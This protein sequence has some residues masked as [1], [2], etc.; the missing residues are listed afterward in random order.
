MHLEIRTNYDEE[1]P[2]T[3]LFFIDDKN[4][5][6]LLKSQTIYGFVEFQECIDALRNFSRLA[7]NQEI[8]ILHTK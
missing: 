7:L 8:K 3:K 1:S 4:T 5:A 2:T 6:T